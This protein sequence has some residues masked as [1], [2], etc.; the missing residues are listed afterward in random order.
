MKAIFNTEKITDSYILL[1]DLSNSFNSKTITN[2]AEDVVKH[3]YKLGLLENK[4]LYYI[5]TD[6]FTSE[7][8][9]D[10]KGNFIWFESIPKEIQEKL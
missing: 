10:G 1:K 6:G 5:D 2:D 8:T 4:K 7:I 9:H 3:F